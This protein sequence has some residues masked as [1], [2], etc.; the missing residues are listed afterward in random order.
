MEDPEAKD[1]VILIINRGRKLG[2]LHNRCR[3]VNVMASGFTEHQGA[4]VLRV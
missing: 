1:Q 3:P 2:G 4:V